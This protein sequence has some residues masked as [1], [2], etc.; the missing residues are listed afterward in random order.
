MGVRGMCP[1]LRW[2]WMTDKSGNWAGEEVP[3]RFWNQVRSFQGDSLEMG[4]TTALEKIPLAEH[5]RHCD[6]RI[7][8]HIPIISL[9]TGNC[10]SLILPYI[11]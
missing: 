9:Y 7:N 3:A 2:A 1:E 10:H 8:I 11:Q 4:G 6:S 5:K